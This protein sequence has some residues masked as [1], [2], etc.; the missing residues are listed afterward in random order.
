MAL[1]PLACGEL[2]DGPALRAIIVFMVFSMLVTWSCLRL[3]E[4]PMKVVYV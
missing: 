1:V 3:V 4:L 2:E